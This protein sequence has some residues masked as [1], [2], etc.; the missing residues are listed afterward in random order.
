MTSGTTQAPAHLLIGCGDHPVIVV[1]GWVGDHRSFQP[2][3]NDLDRDRFTYAFMDARGYGAARAVEGEYTIAEIGE[4]VLALADAHGWE[5]FSLIGHSMGAMAVQRVLRTDTDRV[6]AMI[7]ITPVPAS[8]AEFDEGAWDLFSRAVD[9]LDARTT[10]FTITSGDRSSPTWVKRI[11]RESFERLD[12]TAMASYLKS[13]ANDGFSDDIAG[14]QTPVLV[15]VG[16]HDPAIQR[17]GM[18][19]T[20][21]Q[22]YPN[23]ELDTI[24]NA[25]HYPMDES[26]VSLVTTV[27][28][29]LDKH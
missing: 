19:A 15:L 9:D 12:P 29:F 11:A 14:I 22:W 20:Y 7:G 25:A 18:E 17:E 28:R 27:E 5:R 3:W 10:V 24:A 1:H 8:G 4:D 26:P 16:E 21:L 13:H 6:R 2:L 23:A